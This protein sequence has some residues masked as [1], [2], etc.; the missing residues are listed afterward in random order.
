MYQSKEIR[1]F[2]EQNI[3]H[4]TK[5]F[6]DKGVEFSQVSPR[7]DYYH[8]PSLSKELGIKIREGRLELK[9]RVSGPY[10]EELFEGNTGQFEEWIKWSFEL[11]NLDEELS[12]IL[13]D[14]G[15]HHWLKVRKQRMAVKLGLNE[16]SELQ[17]YD[18]SKLLNRGCQ[19]EYTRI[20]ISDDVWYTF[21]LEWFGEQWIEIK[22]EIMKEILGNAFF[23]QVD[24]K[25]YPHFIMGHLNL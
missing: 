17:I 4:L 8:I 2:F 20:K 5:W 11:K 23:K 24:A 18:P 21:G 22:P 3:E 10:S 1:W 13:N 15:D 25:S 12:A 16:K 6:K 9:H 19:V 14:K 7:V